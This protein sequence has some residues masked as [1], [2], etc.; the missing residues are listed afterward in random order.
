MPLNEGGAVRN[1]M[2]VVVDNGQDLK[3]ELVTLSTILKGTIVLT[4]PAT[5]FVDRAAATPT[6]V[7]TW[8]NGNAAFK[9]RAIA[10]LDEATGRL[11]IRSRNLGKLFSIQVLSGP[12]GIAIFNDFTL[13]NLTASTASNNV[14]RQWNL[15]GR[16]PT[17][18]NDPKV[19]WTPGSISYQL[20]KVDDLAP[21]TY[22]ASIEFKDRGAV[23]TS[24]FRTPSVAKKVFQVKQAAEEKAIANNCD[25]CHQSPETK[26]GLIFDFYR[27]HK[28]LDGTAVDQCGACHDNQ[29]SSAT[30]SWGGAGQ[31]MRRVHGVH[32]GATLNFPLLTV[33]YANGDPMPGR[34]W[35]ITFPE[36]LRNCEVCHTKA[37]TSGTWK[38]KPARLP[39]GGCHDSEAATAHMSVMTVDPTPANPAS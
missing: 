11:A 15:D 19:T 6:E 10:Y 16:A 14:A 24:N 29:T 35:D 22:I 37:T 39:C 26:K 5:G 32:A 17:A 20:D 30:G 9:A 33:G 12:L 8:L 36:D 38:T 27:H 25:T 1:T 13:K 34:N 28:I 21:G 2:T 7:M 3:R 31:I 18:A 4:V 23:D